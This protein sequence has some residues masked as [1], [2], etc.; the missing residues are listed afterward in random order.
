MKALFFDTGPVISLTTNNLLWI[1]PELKK[2]FRGKFYI[3]PSTRRELIEKPLEIKK[4]KFEALQVLRLIE[5]GV[6]DVLDDPSLDAETVHLLGL[7]N[8]SFSAKGSN[9]SMINYAEMSAVVAAVK[10]GAEAVVID[11]RST[12][13][14]IENPEK[15]EEVFENKLH[16]D[17]II[18]RKNLNEFL[19]HVERIKVIR[20]VELAVIAFELGLLDQF[21][22]GIPN[23]KKTLLDSLLWGVKIRGC[24]ISE[25]EIDEIVAMEAR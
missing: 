6:L 1:L 5:G 7:A 9:I 2:R 13:L 8:T 20:S 17:V 25:K 16:T 11:E 24:A 15:L 3:T 14:I 18:D 23:P 4:Y 19:H 10:Y 22:L 12:K 21:V